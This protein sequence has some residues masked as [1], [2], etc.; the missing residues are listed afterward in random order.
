[1]SSAWNSSLETREIKLLAKHAYVQISKEIATI[2]VTIT[3]VFLVQIIKK[4]FTVKDAQWDI[5]KT[6]IPKN[7]IRTLFVNNVAVTE[8]LL[9]AQRTPVSVP[10]AKE[11]RT[12]CTA[13]PVS[14]VST[15]M[16]LE[17]VLNASVTR[18]GR[19][20]WKTIL[21]TKKPANASANLNTPMNSTARIVRPAFTC[22]KS[23]VA[24][25]VTAN[26]PPD[27]ATVQPEHAI[28]ILESPVKNVTA[29][30][31]DIFSLTIPLGVNSASAT[32][33]RKRV[34]R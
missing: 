17:N 13:K 11:I 24:A 15:K 18:P 21:A 30:T 7:L 27:R 5:G 8:S 12:V 16:K 32:V 31:L 10:H 29:A 25:L 19:I 1:M 22:A 26:H 34:T 4:A 14:T 28:V 6:K 23:W 20:Q 2:W 3:S 9:T 33:S